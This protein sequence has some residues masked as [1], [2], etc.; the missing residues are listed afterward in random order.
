[1]NWHFNIQMGCS[2]RVIE[3]EL[4]IFLLMFS[5][6]QL[7][8]SRKIFKIQLEFSTYLCFH[9]SFPLLVFCLSLTDVAISEK[10]GISCTHKPAPWLQSGVARQTKSVLDKVRAVTISDTQFQSAAK[11]LSEPKGMLALRHQYY[12]LG[13]AS[14]SAKTPF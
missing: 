1:M 13:K 14:V 11:C 5:L 10:R 8:Y 4:L 9:S 2:L 7:H 6:A 12:F 3:F